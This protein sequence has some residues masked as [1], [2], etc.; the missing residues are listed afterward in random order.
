MLERSSDT[1]GWKTTALR[2]LCWPPRSC[3]LRKRPTLST[4]SEGGTENAMKEYYATILI[5]LNNLIDRV[6]ET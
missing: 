3:G 2:S 6:R 5:R 1:S 4:T